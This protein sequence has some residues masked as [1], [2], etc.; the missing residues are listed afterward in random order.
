VNF[1]RIKNIE[2]HVSWM[3]FHVLVTSPG[4]PGLLTSSRAYFLWGHLKSR[5]YKNKPHTLEELEEHIRDEIR[6]I[7][8]GLLQ[9]VRV[10][11]QS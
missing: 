6:T 2:S 10:N 3:S 8:K 4:Q 11:F 9:A 7:D 1:S 5:V